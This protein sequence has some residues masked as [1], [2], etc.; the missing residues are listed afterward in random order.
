MSQKVV[1][2]FQRLGELD[3]DSNPVSRDG[4]GARELVGIGDL[5]ADGYLKTL[6][7]Y[8]KILNAPMVAD[9]TAGRPLPQ[10]AAGRVLLL[11]AEVELRLQPTTGLIE[12]FKN[13][14]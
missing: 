7:G 3:S 6:P 12:A 9:D 11:L 5:D 8:S 10:A 2:Q 14:Q 13:T 4:A 1:K